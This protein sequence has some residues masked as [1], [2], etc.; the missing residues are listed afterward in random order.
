MGNRK[1]RPQM[2]KRTAAEMQRAWRLACRHD[3]ISPSESFVVFSPTNPHV[4]AYRE[5]Q[6]A[7]LKAIR[8]DLDRVKELR[9]ETPST[10]PEVSL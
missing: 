10:S 4:A 2:I 1:S 8:G 7:F 5:S 6:K 9:P 3:N